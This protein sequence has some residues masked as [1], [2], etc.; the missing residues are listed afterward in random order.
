MGLCRLALVFIFN[1]V[2]PTPTDA[3]LSP[4]LYFFLISNVY[5]DFCMPVLGR[6][7]EF[8]IEEIITE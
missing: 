3:G 7:A 6:T 1:I 4:F 2:G 8:K 5:Y